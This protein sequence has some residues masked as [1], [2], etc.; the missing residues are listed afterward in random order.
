[1]TATLLSMT[2]ALI[3]LLIL[4]AVTLGLGWWASMIAE[5]RDAW[6]FGIDE[7]ERGTASVVARKNKDGSVTIVHSSYG[8]K[9]TTND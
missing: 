3:V 8:P 1:M 4:G 2:P 9:E 7:T 5:G 6:L